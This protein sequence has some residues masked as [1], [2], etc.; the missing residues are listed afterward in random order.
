MCFRI[1]ASPAQFTEGMDNM[2]NGLPDM[3]HYLD[4]L[5]VRGAILEKH[6][7]NLENLM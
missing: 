6:W 5:I 4:D 2:I 7:T 3:A 1:A